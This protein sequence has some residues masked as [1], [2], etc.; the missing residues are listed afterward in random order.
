M[1]LDSP[2]QADWNDA[3]LCRADFTGISSSPIQAVTLANKRSLI[4]KG[5]PVFAPDFILK[6]LTYIVKPPLS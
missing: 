2:P 6:V 1:S 4:K 3:T 5:L